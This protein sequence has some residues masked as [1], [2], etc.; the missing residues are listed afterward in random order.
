MYSQYRRRRSARLD[1]DTG[2]QL[3]TYTGQ[4]R[5]PVSDCPP[6][7]RPAISARL[8]QEENVRTSKRTASLGRA[9]RQATIITTV[10]LL[11]TAMAAS[12][13]SADPARSPNASPTVPADG[14]GARDKD[15]RGHA[16]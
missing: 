2:Q 16:N 4:Y 1:D 15:N 11:C 7:D 14:H 12:R 6:A 13:S 9:F 8:T 3:D 5:D 10:V